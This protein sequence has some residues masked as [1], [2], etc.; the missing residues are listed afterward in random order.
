MQPK[1]TKLYDKRFQKIE[2]LGEGTYGKVYKVKV[3]NTDKDEYYALKKY[4]KGYFH[5][6]MDI[7]ALREITIL[8]EISHENIVKIHELFYGMTSLYVAYEYLDCELSKIIFNYEIDL[9][10][11]YIKGLLLQMLRGL[12]EIHK[13]GVLHRDLK[14]QNLLV[15]KEGLLKIAD[16]G[17]ARFIAS[18]G[19]E[20]TAGVISDWYRPPEIFFG[21]KYYSYGV[22]IWSTGCIFA[23][24]ITKIPLFE[25]KNEIEILKKIFS[26]LGVPNESDWPD[27]NQLDG[28]KLFTQGD[29]ITIKKKFSNL[30]KEGVDLLEKML[31]LDP[32]KRISAREALEHPFFQVEPLPCSNKEIATLIEKIKKIEMSSNNKE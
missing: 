8:K 7:T 14:P 9:N 30:S 10:E 24:M 21:A 4:E 32:N 12:G 6:G 29:V 27:C 28:F 3:P 26:L 5:E 22:D 17:F 25:G 16:F 31:A 13:Y 11:S 15:S 18:P 19:R 23:E 1:N 20:M 2:K